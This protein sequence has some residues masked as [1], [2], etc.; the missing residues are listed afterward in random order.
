[1]TKLEF[2]NKLE[3]YHKKQ[4]VNKWLFFIFGIVFITF[5][6]IPGI[7]LSIDENMFGFTSTTLAVFAGLCLGKAWDIKRGSEE[8]ELLVNALDLL[9]ANND[10]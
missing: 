7:I 6:F 2:A 1:M 8:H 4:T 3:K 9:S 10:T 5:V